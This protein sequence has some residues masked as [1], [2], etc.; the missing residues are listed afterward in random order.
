VLQEVL[1]LLHETLTAMHAIMK[2]LQGMAKAMQET[3]KALQEVVK[4]LYAT[5]KAL[6][7][8]VKVLQG[9]VKA[10][11]EALKGLHNIPLLKKDYEK[12][13]GPDLRCF[14]Q[15]QFPDCHFPHFYFTNFPG[16]RH[17]E[18]VD[19]F[20]IPGNFIMCNFMLA[21]LIQVFSRNS[22]A[23]F[24]FYPCHYFFAIFFTWHANHLD[25]FN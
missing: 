18:G 13:R 4:A 19:E 21:K 1:N 24:Y 6:Q 7:G 25:V 5:V 10:L 23:D 15:A 8:M 9:T 11:R 14:L 12:L 3:V 20:P 2:V 16:Y 22:V 17:R